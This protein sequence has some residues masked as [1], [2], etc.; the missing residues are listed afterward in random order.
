MYWLVKK[1]A[2]ST[3]R[4]WVWYSRNSSVWLMYHTPATDGC[5]WGRDRDSSCI[6]VYILFGPLSDHMRVVVM[7]RSG[8]QTLT[9]HSAYCGGTRDAIAMHKAY[10]A[11]ITK[12]AGIWQKFQ[13]AKSVNF[14]W[15]IN[16]IFFWFLILSII[17]LLISKII[18]SILMK[19]LV[20]KILNNFL[21]YFIQGTP[22]SIFAHFHLV[23]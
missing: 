2:D 17:L 3:F 15:K 16:S 8:N 12:F 20:Q 14:T 5:W 9:E 1:N 18:I 19:L 10:L 7:T 21:L 4:P 13:K 6:R 23:Y 11:L 22:W